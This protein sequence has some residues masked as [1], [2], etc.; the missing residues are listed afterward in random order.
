MMKAVKTKKKQFS[1]FDLAEAYKLL[2]ITHLM[3][4][5]LEAPSY[6]PSDFFGVRL[7]RLRQVFDLRRNEEAKKMLIDAF[8]EEAML[9]F[10]R[11]RIW[12]GAYLEGETTCG[13]ADYLVAENRDYLEDPFMCVVEAKKDD[14]EQGLAQCLVE[15]QACQWINQQSD[16]ATDIYGIVTNGTTWRFYLL[17]LDGI[18]YE[19]LDYSLKDTG[20]VLGALRYI[21]QQCQYNLARQPSSEIG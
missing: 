9:E 5:D 20:S 3:S 16:H 11:L 21:F 7:D 2:T 6:P 8:C 4:W 10:K 12:K 1:S 19:S 18:G 15:M 17:N 13:S 14:F